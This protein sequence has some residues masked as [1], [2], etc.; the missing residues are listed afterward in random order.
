VSATEVTHPTVALD[1]LVHQRVRLG[2]LAVLVEVKRADFAY[3]RRTLELTDGNLSRQLQVLEEA[4][5]VEIEKVFESK[6]P[7]TWLSLT[8]QGRAALR[9]EREALRALVERLEQLK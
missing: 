6:R 8:K 3:L 9:A 4:G 1:A 5:Y 2:I 7:R